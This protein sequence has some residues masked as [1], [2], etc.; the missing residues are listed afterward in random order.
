MLKDELTC[1]RCDGAGVL[2]SPKQNNGHTV[3]MG[4]TICG[5]CNGHGVV[6]M[7][8]KVAHK[9]NYK[10]KRGYYACDVANSGFERSLA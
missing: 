4:V 7:V 8:E 6:L 5:G 2:P 10:T 9:Y 1:V 3:K